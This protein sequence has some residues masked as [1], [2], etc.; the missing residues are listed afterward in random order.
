MTGRK[1]WEIAS[2]MGFIEAPVVTGDG[3]L[4]VADV[5]G[6]WILRIDP[7]S[8]KVERCIETGGGPNGLALGPG[9]DM[10]VCNNG[11]M[12]STVS[13]EGFNTPLGDGTPA[14]N[15]VRPAIQIVDAGGAVRDLYVACAGHPLSAPNDL[16]FDA[17]GGFYFTDLGHP[18]GRYCDLGGLFYAK[19]D[20]SAIVE[21]IHEVGP[22]TPLTQ[23]NGVALSPCGTRIYVA[24]TAAGRV[25]AWDIKA[26]GV[27]APSPRAVSQNGGELLF[28]HN[29]YT[30]F[31]SM[32]VDSA[33]NI[34]VATLLRGGISVISPEGG[35]V[36]FI[37]LPE[38]DPYVT[39]ICFGGP[40]RT[41]AYVTA[42]ARGKI[43]AIDWPRPGLRLAHSA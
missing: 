32:A 7:A 2:G 12:A 15:P 40:D 39:N 6:G 19:A 18:H 38:F 37:E 4:L 22:A 34:C 21:L 26:P 5:T 41:T 25:W 24:E 14:P 3:S 9:G 31:D 11:G 8:G 28:G 27:L 10:F 36:E 20:G 42:A 23:P 13:A 30:L 29:D 16:V 1:I 43:W 17:F 35:L 33:G